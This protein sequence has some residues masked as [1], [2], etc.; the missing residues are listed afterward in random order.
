MTSTDEFLVNGQ[1]G[2]YTQSKIMQFDY[3]PGFA[4]GA[5]SSAY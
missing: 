1:V 5:V 3:S 2:N 4:F